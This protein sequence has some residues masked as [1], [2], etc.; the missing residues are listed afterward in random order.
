MNLQ[1]LRYVQAVAA[2]RMSVSE[3]ALALHTSQPGV[4]KQ[5]RALEAELGS[6]LF[7][8]QG[9]RFTGMTDAGREVLAKIDAVDDPAPDSL[10]A[11]DDAELRALQAIIAKLASP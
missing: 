5:I 8:R 10:A 4:S 9:R 1:Q 7:V 6:D 11:L 3:A 2:H